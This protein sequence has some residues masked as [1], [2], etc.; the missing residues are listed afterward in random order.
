MSGPTHDSRSMHANGY[1]YYVIMYFRIPQNQIIDT[2]AN[3]DNLPF[4]IEFDN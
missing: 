2:E 1:N 3:S 4:D